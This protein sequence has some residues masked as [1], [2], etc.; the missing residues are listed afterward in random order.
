[1]LLFSEMH[2]HRAAFPVLG[3]F[4]MSPTQ[5]L[6]S[7]K[8][9]LTVQPPVVGLMESLLWPPMFMK[10]IDTEDSASPFG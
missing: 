4:A 3:A 9:D 8:G 5:I 2:A 6:V 1:M 10:P 7:N